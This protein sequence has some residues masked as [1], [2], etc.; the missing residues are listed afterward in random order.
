MGRRVVILLM[1]LLPTFFCR[2][3]FPTGLSPASRQSIYGFGA[4]SVGPSVDSFIGTNLVN[5]MKSNVSDL[6][7]LALSFGIPEEK[8]EH[9]YTGIGDPDTVEGVI[10]RVIVEEGLVIYDGAVSQIVLTAFGR[11]QDLEQ[12]ETMIH[13]YWDGKIGELQSIRA[14]GDFVYDPFSPGLVSGDPDEKGKRGFIYRIINAHGRYNTRDPLDG[15]TYMADFPNWPDIHWEDWKPVAGENAWV[16]MAAMHLYHRKYYDPQTGTYEY[17]PDA[18]E[19]KLAEELARAA[20]LLRADNGGI[21]MAPLGTYRNPRDFTDKNMRQG[22]WWYNQISTENNISWYAAFRMLYQVTG[23]DIYKD[24]FEGI[25]RYFQQVFNEE[26][27]Y[28]YQG[29]NFCDGAW[30]TNT[31]DFALDVQTWAIAALGPQKIDE[32]FGSGAARAMWT[33][34]RRFSGFFDQDKVMGVGYTYEHDQLS[35]EWTAGAILAVQMLADY[36]QDRM[37]PEGVWQLQE[38]V[39]TM[40]Q[41]I[42]RLRTDLSPEKSAYAYSL[43]RKYI[44]FGWYAHSSEVLSLASTGWVVMIDN[45]FNPFSLEM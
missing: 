31:Q 35:V 7:G 34:G 22:E 8:K 17:V 9:V 29:M 12:V 42:E 43:K 32:W 3:A 4:K 13:V 1:I 16:T 19:Y 45:Q 36:Y 25:E 33:A 44:P 10:E 14:G 40:R 20:I 18:A 21:R 37:D 2:A 24:A 28:F 30:H 39:R 11:E 26:G 27:R 23:K 15:K 41:G 5:W 38:D 6:T